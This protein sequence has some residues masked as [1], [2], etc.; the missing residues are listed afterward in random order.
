LATTSADLYIA[1]VPEPASIGLIGLAAVGM[2]RRR[3]K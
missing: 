3:S 1:P 2:L